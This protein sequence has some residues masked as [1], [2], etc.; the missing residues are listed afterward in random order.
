MLPVR[1]TVHAGGGFDVGEEQIQYET[2]GIRG[3]YRGNRI[4]LLREEFV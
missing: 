2:P 4:A 1:Y 3:K